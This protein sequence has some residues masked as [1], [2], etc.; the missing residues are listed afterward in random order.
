MKRKLLLSGL[1]GTIALTLVFSTVDSAFSGQNKAM[2]SAE[3]SATGTLAGTGTR[4]PG[5]EHCPAA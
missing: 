3:I 5:Q 4:L 1:V 2:K